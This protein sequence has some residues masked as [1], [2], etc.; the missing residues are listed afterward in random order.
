MD[1][2]ADGDQYKHDND[3]IWNAMSSINIPGSTQLVAIRCYN[4]EGWCGINVGLSNGVRTDTTWKCSEEE[5]EGWNTV[6][7]NDSAWNKAKLLQRS[8][9]DWIW[10]N[11]NAMDM[12]TIYCRKSILVEP[13]SPTTTVVEPSS[14]TTTVVEPSTATTTVEEL[15]TATTRVVEL[16]ATTTTVVEPSSLNTTAGGLSTATTT[17]VE[18]SSPTTTVGE[19]STV[20]TTVVQPCLPTTTV[21]ELS[22]ATTTVV[23]PCSPT[24]TVVELST[25]TTTVVEPSTATTTVVEPCSPTTTVEDLCSPTTTVVM[26]CT[27]TTDFDLQPSSTGVAVLGS[28]GVLRSQV[29]Q[30]V[31]VVTSE[32]A[33]KE[34]AVSSIYKELTLNKS[35]ISAV[36][37]KKVSQKDERPSSA[38]IGYF[39]LIFAVLPFALLIISDIPKLIQHLR[40]RMR[41]H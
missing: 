15:S 9:V 6:G 2:Y 37:R 30:D 32:S 27:Q 28:D 26:P 21:M 23:E 1:L 14:T 41:A 18:S 38:T 8:N 11:D 35:K 16:S 34:A 12:G 31:V 40:T 13:Y 36:I 10:T 24:T 39:G 7:F 19:L 4:L 29:C 25:V 5:E 3:N 20:T 22:T 33:M 17:V